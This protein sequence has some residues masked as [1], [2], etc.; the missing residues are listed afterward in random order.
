MKKFEKKDSKI[1]VI[2]F[3]KEEYKTTKT[4]NRLSETT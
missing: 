2:T 4:V 1:T 3:S